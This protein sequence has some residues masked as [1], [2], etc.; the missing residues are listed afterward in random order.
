VTANWYFLMRTLLLTDLHLT[1]TPPGLLDAQKNCI[2]EIF[3]KESPD[4]VIIMGDLVMARRPKPQVLVAL[5]AIIKTFERQCPVVLIRGNHDSDNR[6]DD[7]L[8]ILSLFE[9]TNVRVITQTEHD[10]DKKRTYIPHY[11]DQGRIKVLLNTVPKDHRVFGHFGY[12]GCL[13][14]C[15]DADFSISLASFGNT[16]YLGHIHRFRRDGKVTILG[17][18]YSTNF[19][20]SGKDNYY[21]IMDEHDVEFFQID[22]GPRYL[23]LDRGDVEDRLEEI[24]NSDYFTILRVNLS[25]GD[26]DPPYEKIDAALVEVKFKPAFDEEHLSNFTPRRDLFSLNEVILED[27]IDS[28]NTALPKDKIMEGFRLIKNED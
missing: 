27:Y 9:S 11:E 1:H 2:L 21:A 18:P 25:P 8:T 6:S 23:M 13:N 17:T 3:E 4:E 24:N 26:T 15:G 14:S 20:E 16:T 5:H 7:G 28:A 12:A 10:Y 19:G 22:F